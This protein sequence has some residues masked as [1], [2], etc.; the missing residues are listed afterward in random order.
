MQL[1]LELTQAFQHG[2][3]R[4]IL[5]FYQTQGSEQHFHTIRYQI[6]IFFF[7]KHIQLKNPIPSSTLSRKLLS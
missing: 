4:I 7:F 3:W 2:N 1:L 5:L 6:Y